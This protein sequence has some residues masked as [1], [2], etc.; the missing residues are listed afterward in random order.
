MSVLE[1][2]TLLIMGELQRWGI[3]VPLAPS[4]DSSLDM[5]RLESVISLWT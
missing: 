2:S 1:I 5:C 4:V 3:L